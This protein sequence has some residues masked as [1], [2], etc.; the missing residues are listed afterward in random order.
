MLQVE[1]IDGEVETL[2]DRDLMQLKADALFTHDAAGRILTSNETDPEWAPRLF[3]G[4][5]PD[6]NVWRFRDDLSTDVVSELKRLCREE[7][8][9]ADPRQRAVMFDA[10]KAV[11]E[12][13]EPVVEV[14]EG[15]TWHVPRP[16]VAT[17]RA[18][19]IGPENRDFLEVHF[20]YAAEHLD[21]QWPVCA[22]VMGGVAVST[23]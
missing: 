15:P 7:P 13:R 8:P 3:L 17:D 18:V 16:L 12:A 1:L 10:L 2:N 4:R 23:C 21:E 19:S 6:G 9:L 20:P 14:W 5:T 22:V 11:L